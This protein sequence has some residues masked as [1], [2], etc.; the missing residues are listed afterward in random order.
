M[1]GYVDIHAHVL[2][3][4]DDGPENVDQSLAMP[5]AAANSGIQTIA[6]TPHLRRDFPDVRVEELAH[7]C[8]TL[9]EAVE[10]RE[11]PVRIVSGA[12]MSLSWALDASDDELA[13]ASYEQRGTDLLLETPTT[14]SPTIESVVAH[15][16]AKGYRVTLAHPE[17]APAFQRDL[18]RLR[19]LVGRGVLLA[20]NS[21]SLLS[22]RALRTG[23]FARH[24]F[25]EGLAHALVSDGHRA[26]RW[27]PVTVLQ[28]AVQ[29]ATVLV[30]HERAGWLVQQAPGAIIAGQDLPVA[31]PIRAWHR[32]RWWFGRR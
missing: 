25:T 5:R 22:S 14:N 24:L 11:I 30:G 29:A 27:L 18:D 26:E 20:V 28:S 16:Q 32:Q 1:S 3:G 8:Q 17:C 31:P 4:I 10:Q 6:A 13:L 7:R 23:R 9:R 15:L 19:R 2:P 21:D 12:E